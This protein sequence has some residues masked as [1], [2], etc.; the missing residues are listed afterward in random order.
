MLPSTRTR[1]SSEHTTTESP[2]FEPQTA[3]AL[4]D[5]LCSDDVF[6]AQFSRNPLQACRQIGLAFDSM[7]QVPPCLSTGKL[8][9][10]EELSQARDALVNYLSS[11]RASM[12]VVFTFEAGHVHRIIQ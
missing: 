3:I 10:K 9:S 7:A 12:T 5:R 4:L 8:A 1:F 11:H 2:R 6:R